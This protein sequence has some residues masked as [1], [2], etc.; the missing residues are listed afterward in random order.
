MSRLALQR[1]TPLPELTAPDDEFWQMVRDL[2]RR[3]SQAVA[4]HYLED[5]PVAKV[6]DILEC[7]ESTAKVH[8]HKARKSLAK[9]MKPAEEGA[10]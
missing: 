10:V 8:L 7:S 1:Q 3:Q 4:L 6:A 2:P 5:R 9:R